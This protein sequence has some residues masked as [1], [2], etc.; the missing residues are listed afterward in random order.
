MADQSG[1]RAPPLPRGGEDSDA[2]D[3]SSHDSSS[4]YPDDLPPARETPRLSFAAIGH[5]VRGIFRGTSEDRGLSRSSSDAQNIAGAPQT[6][7]QRQTGTPMDVEDAQRDTSTADNAP[8]TSEDA[9]DAEGGAGPSDPAEAQEQGEDAEADLLPITAFALAIQHAAAAN[10]EMHRERGGRP[11]SPAFGT[12]QRMTP[13]PTQAETEQAEPEE[14]AETLPGY[15]GAARTQESGEAASTTNTSSNAPGGAGSTNETNSAPGPPQP[16]PTIVLF[17]LPFTA[18]DGRQALLAFRPIPL[19]GLATPEGE[20]AGQRSHPHPIGHVPVNPVFV[21]VGVSPFQFALLYDANY[22]LGWPVVPVEVDPASLASLGELRPHFMA[23]MPFQIAFHFHMGGEGD[24]QEEQPSKEKAEKYVANLER[25][26]AELRERMARLGLGDIGDYSDSSSSLMDTHGTQG[27][28][29]CLE[30][31]ASEDKPEWVVGKQRAEDEAVVAVPCAGHHTL[32]ASCLRG[33]L[34]NVKPSAW[35]CPFCRGPLAIPPSIEGS[36]Q[37]Q[38]PQQSQAPAQGRDAATAAGTAQSDEE[39]R[40][41]QAEQAQSQARSLRD[42]VRFRE[43]QRGW[44]CDAAACLA[45]YPADPK[46]SSSSSS[47]SSAAT[48]NNE[49]EDADAAS[50]DPDAELVRLAPCHHEIHAGCLRTAMRVEADLLTPLDG[51]DDDEED[52]EEGGGDEEED[53]DV[54]TKTEPIDMMRDRNTISGDTSDRKRKRESDPNGS[55]PSDGDVSLVMP[56]DAVSTA[57]SDKD[58]RPRRTVGKWVN[59]PTCRSECWA[60]IPVDE[61]RSRASRRRRRNEGILG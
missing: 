11:T 17:R 57:T 51:E 20:G 6:E 38:Q 35:T 23:G 43:R 7:A 41:L 44:R 50:S 36:N 56:M 2:P 21:P 22:G 12:A 18:S 26:D 32:H 47:S 60:E 55:P 1:S 61:S 48:A 42:E 53:G 14:P 39:K 8:P 10:D 54:A 16:P 46:T 24:V 37:Q 27:C 28:G 52:E 25:A 31:F 33:W 40:R 13:P 19:P 49:G 29:I 58:R 4:S 34:E 59:C 15:E 45:R 9:P 30:G 3:N 5:A